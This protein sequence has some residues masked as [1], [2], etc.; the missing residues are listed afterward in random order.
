MKTFQAEPRRARGT[1][2]RWQE[3]YNNEQGNSSE[4]G[5]VSGHVGLVGSDHPARMSGGGA[6]L[7]SQDPAAGCRRAPASAS[8]SGGPWRTRDFCTRAQA[9]AGSAS[10]AARQR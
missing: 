4:S 5:V 10:A 8:F 3:G 9:Q 1:G 6:L 2:K 7:K